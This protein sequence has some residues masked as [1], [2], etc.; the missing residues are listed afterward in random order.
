MLK[1]NISYLSLVFK[2]IGLK[3]EK[4]KVSNEFYINIETMAYVKWL[5]C[6]I[7]F[8]EFV[9]K[10]WNFLAN[11]KDSFTAMISFVFSRFKRMINSRELLILEKNFSVGWMQTMLSF[12]FI[13]LICVKLMWIKLNWYELHFLLKQNFYVL[14]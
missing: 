7:I 4:I 3:V 13:S 1:K 2:S 5:Y 8:K 10:R 9:L 11:F 6:V 12:G 14:R